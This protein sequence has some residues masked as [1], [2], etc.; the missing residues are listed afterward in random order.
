MHKTVQ[1]LKMEHKAGSFTINPPAGRR[2][3]ARANEENL[4]H[5]EA[6]DIEKIKN[7]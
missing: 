1:L 6:K 4:G 7:K 2:N 3:P 5:L